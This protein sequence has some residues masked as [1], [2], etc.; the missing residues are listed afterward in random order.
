MH[1]VAVRAEY[2]KVREVIVVLIAVQMSDLENLWDPKATICTDRS[3]AFESQFSVF[4]SLL[5]SHTSR[6]PSHYLLRGERSGHV[7]RMSY[8]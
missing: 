4:A 8:R 1:L 2:S 6:T 7:D 3:I 5:L